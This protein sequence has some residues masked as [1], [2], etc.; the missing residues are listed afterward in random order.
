MK[1]SIK[2]FI[3]T[4]GLSFIGQAQNVKEGIQN[5]RQIRES[6]KN[7]ERDI[8]ELEAFNIELRN[9]KK[10]VS[11]KDQVEVDRITSELIK[12]MEREVGQSEI[13]AKKA[14]REISQSSA[15]VRSDR[16]EN[17]DN[18]EDSRRTRYDRRDDQRDAARDRANT[19][20]DMRDRRDDIADFKRQIAIAEQQKKLLSTLKVY[21][22][23]IED[24]ERDAYKAK[25]QD[26]KTKYKSFIALLKEDIEMTKRELAED[27]RERRED[28]RERRDDRNEDDE[29]EVTR[30]RRRG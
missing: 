23:T 11:K 2:L 7:L 12:A 30:R 27:S 26:I 9:M 10:A 21:D 1:I 5:T 13:K 22:Y 16:R 20:D 25:K 6:K 14:R 29:I 3:M 17:E 28:S 4:L 15:E 19:R 18:R 24:I 8:K